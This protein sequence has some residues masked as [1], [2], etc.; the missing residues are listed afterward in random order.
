MTHK[1]D[2]GKIL[3]KGDCASDGR[4]TEIPKTVIRLRMIE[5]VD[6]KYRTELFICCI[7]YTYYSIKQKSIKKEKF[8][9]SAINI[10]L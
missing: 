2:R 1:N 5:N 4:D 10:I 3:W 7:L 8:C 6:F 9:I